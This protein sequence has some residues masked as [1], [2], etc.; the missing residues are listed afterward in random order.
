[1]S[2]FEAMSST[3]APGSWGLHGGN[4]PEL[5]ARGQ[6]V[7]V[8]LHRPQRDGAAQLGVR[9]P[10][11]VLLW[12]RAAERVGEAAFKGALF[13]CMA[14]AALNMKQNVEGQRART[15][16][17]PSSGR[18]DEIWPTGGGARSVRPAQHARPAAWRPVEAAALLA[19]EPLGER[20]ACEEGEGVAA[21][22]HAKP[23]PPAHSPTHI[24]TRTLL[25]LSTH[26]TPPPP[27]LPSSHPTPPP[28]PPPPPLLSSVR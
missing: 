25:L 10:G 28:P 17:A 27:P 2:S 24:H 18:L 7:C 4:V 6:D 19:D 15:S 11:V 23:P 1:M 9:Q 3:L 21:L 13:Q 5:R 22:T 12:A 26:P 16:S 20:G 14:A 8:Q